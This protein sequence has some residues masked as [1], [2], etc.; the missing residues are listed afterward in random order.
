VALLQYVRFH[1]T[2]LFLAAGAGANVTLGI[3]RLREII[4]TASRAIKTPTMS[5]PLD[6]SVTEKQG[7]KLARFLTKLT[8]SELVASQGGI[9][10]VETLMQGDAGNWQ[11]A[12]IVT[13]KLHPAER[14]MEAFGLSLR[15]VATVVG[16]AFVP[17]LAYLMKQELRRSAVEGDVGAPS[18]DGADSSKFVQDVTDAGSSRRNDDDN[19]ADELENTGNENDDDDEGAV[20]EEDGVMA[21]R[22]GHK[23]EMDTYE[24]MDD[25]DRAATNQHLSEDEV[26]DGEEEAPSSIPADDEEQRE[27]TSFK[28][29]QGVMISKANNTISLPPLRVDPSARPLLMVGL[30]ERAAATTLV[31]SR[32]KIEQAFVNEEEGR[33]RCLQTAGV[34][35]EEM[36]RLDRVDHNRLMSNDIWAVRCAYGVEA[37]RGNIVEQIRAVF[38]AYGIE[39]DPHHLSLI[40]DY[41]TFEGGYNPMNRI[42]MEGS[43][44]PFLQMSF[45]T[46]THFLTQASLNSRTDD[47]ASPS[48]NLV[49]GRP[50]R[51]GTGTIELLAV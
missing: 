43:S 41:M 48:A 9:K 51:H 6:S 7:V 47:L 10:V 12:Y 31:R 36:W 22:F 40:A 30:V 26:S 20:G 16:K 4:M 23:D 33:G 50:I 24:D 8:L 13:M 1:L 3:P 27:K 25:E 15:D 32:N 35:F 45:E 39:V 37:A 5:I 29:N 44:S 34:N 28:E 11:R 46:T 42:G 49:V 14:I 19:N 17:K 2:L 38:G 21:S 18:V